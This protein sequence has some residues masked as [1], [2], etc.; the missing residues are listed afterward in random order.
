MCVL[1]A[2][3]EVTC[4]SFFFGGGGTVTVVLQAKIMLALIWPCLW[5]SEFR[6]CPVEDVALCHLCLPLAHFFWTIGSGIY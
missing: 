5:T 1:R 4:R 2:I 6:F 3:F